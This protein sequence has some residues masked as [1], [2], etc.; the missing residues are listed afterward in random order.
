MATPQNSGALASI[1]GFFGSLVDKATPVV[2]QYLAY[3]T[4]KE[5]GGATQ[6]AQGYQQSTGPAGDSD[7]RGTVA[8][9][10]GVA[11]IT[12]APWFPYAI[13]GGGLLILGFFGLMLRG[14]RK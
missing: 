11:A 2:N 4:A 1:T 6:T 13:L 12:S 14:S 9:P 8:Q 3:R 10:N 5:G 7:W